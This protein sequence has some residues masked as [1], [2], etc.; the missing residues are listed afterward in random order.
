MYRKGLYAII[1]FILCFSITVHAA[2]L[3]WNANTETDLAGYKVYRGQSS[4]S[5]DEMVDVGNVT[6]YQIEG[7]D[8]GTYNYVV[9]AYNIFGAESKFSNEIIYIKGSEQIT[10]ATNLQISYKEQTIMAVERTGN[11]YCQQENDSMITVPADAE[12]AIIAVKSYFEIP[13]SISLGGV[14]GTFITGDPPGFT[15]LWYVLSPPSG[16][17]TLHFSGDASYHI[18][19]IFYKNINTGS[20]ILDSDYVTEATSLTGLTTE[21]GCMMVGAASGYYEFPDAD[22]NGQTVLC[23]ET[24]RGWSIG[25]KADVGDFYVL[26]SFEDGPWL[27][28]ITLK[29]TAAGIKIP[30]A[31]DIYRQRRN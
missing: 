20:P 24:Y 19:C 30:V 1:V 28:A 29:P 4:G 13:T 3:V 12:I 23:E 15:S 18:N 9:S 10:A 6:E 16:D 25:Q 14:N 5:Y 2:R 21:S 31:M 22:T 11:V 17:Q 27:S 8:P 26:G 7:I